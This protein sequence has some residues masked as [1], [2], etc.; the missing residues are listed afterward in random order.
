[1]K[2]TTTLLILSA[3]L[4]ALP[5]CKPAKPLPRM[6]PLPEFSLISQ[7]GKPIKKSEFQ[8]KVWVANFFFATCPS[9]CKDL[10]GRMRQ[11]DKE[12]SG[13]NRFRLAS[14]TTDAQNDTPEALKKYA[15]GMSASAQWM[16]L[17]GTK[18]DLYKLSIDGFKLALQENIGA[19]DPIIHSGKMVLVDKTGTIRGYYDGV[20]DASRG[21]DGM[22]HL[23]NEQKRL[24][25]DIH[26]LLK[27]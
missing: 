15:E 17:T 7:D 18:A 10:N 1:M 5:G 3:L 22:K 19:G 24:V 2:T 8:G 12:F 9:I 20:A 26:R 6:F 21:D 14:I 25:A 16:F 4:I 27:E 13:E 23:K 11:L